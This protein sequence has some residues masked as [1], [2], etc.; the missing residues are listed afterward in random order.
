MYKIDPDA[1][2][3]INL[4]KE[5]ININNYDY[6]KMMFDFEKSEKR[7]RYFN[8]KTKDSE[9]YNKLHHKKIK[10]FREARDELEKEKQKQL[11]SRLHSKSQTMLTALDL[12]KQSK[13]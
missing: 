9:K 12:T 8:K 7:K 3:L 6:N 11:Q 10:Q 1:K 4:V 13:Y 5:S 2:Q